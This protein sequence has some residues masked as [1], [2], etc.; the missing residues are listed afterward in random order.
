MAV[1]S[2]V[3]AL[4]AVL[5]V[6]G[7]RPQAAG[8]AS[9]KAG[10]IRWLPNH[11]PIEMGDSSLAGFELVTLPGS[12]RSLPLETCVPYRIIRFLNIAYELTRTKGSRRS[13]R[14]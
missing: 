5:R 11:V 9:G 14:Q 1:K 8:R 4:L 2:T 6:G 7:R 12:R 13:R 10:L 3:A